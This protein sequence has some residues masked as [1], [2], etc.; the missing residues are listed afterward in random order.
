MSELNIAVHPL[1]VLN[2][3]DHFT[4]SRYRDHAND[5]AS[6]VVGILLGKQDGRSL[7]IVNSIEV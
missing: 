7:E 3:S 1:V 5:K 4:R 6:R 2:L